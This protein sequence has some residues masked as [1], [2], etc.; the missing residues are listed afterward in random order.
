MFFS[1]T[2]LFEHYGTKK[3]KETLSRL[4]NNKKEENVV[5]YEIL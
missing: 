5:H 4:E 3:E 2:N 1:Y